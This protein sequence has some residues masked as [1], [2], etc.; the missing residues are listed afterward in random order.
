MIMYTLFYIQST[1]GGDSF[2]ITSRAW[3]SPKRRLDPEVVVTA[4]RALGDGAHVVAMFLRIFVIEKQFF[5]RP[6]V[7]LGKN[8]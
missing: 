2:V 3:S 6:D 7:T 8:S 4:A 5:A 1:K